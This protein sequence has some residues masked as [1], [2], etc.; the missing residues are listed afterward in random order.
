MWNSTESVKPIVP[1][2]LTTETNEQNADRG[3]GRD[4]FPQAGFIFE[5][6]MAKV[7][8]PLPLMAAGSWAGFRTQ[9]SL[10]VSPIK[11]AKTE[12]QA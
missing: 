12:F 11:S 10:L 4:S 9:K 2:V 5:S 1:L 3:A 6:A 8:L 7:T